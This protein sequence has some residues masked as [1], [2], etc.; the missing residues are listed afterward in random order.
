MPK[1]KPSSKS[2]IEA[3]FGAIGRLGG[4]MRDEW[5]AGEAEAR[6]SGPEP[7]S[8]TQSARKAG[9]V[10]ASPRWWEVLHVAPTASADEIRQAS[11]RLIKKSHP[12]KFAH[13]APEM[14]ATMEKLAQQL[15]DAYERAIK[16]RT[17]PKG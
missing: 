14:Q 11:R 12:D 13:Q 1:R 8:K 16:G 7:P 6:R 3:A 17:K 4:R 15:N 2:W 9:P 10:P 5:K